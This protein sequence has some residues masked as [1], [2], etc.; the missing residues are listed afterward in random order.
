M[1]VEG[2]DSRQ[3]TEEQL[4][5]LR[6]EENQVLDEILNNNGTIKERVER[7]EQIIK[8]RL[9]LGDPTLDK[10]FTI[11]QISTYITRSLR[12]SNCPTADIVYRY[13][14]DDCKNQSYSKWGKTGKTV[15]MLA[16]GQLPVGYQ[17]EDLSNTEMEVAYEKVLSAKDE[18]D[19][20]ISQLNKQRAQMEFI[21][22]KKHFQLSGNKFRRAIS[23]SDFDE[24]VPKTLEEKVKYNAG[25]I[26]DLGDGLK[27]IAKKYEKSPP[28]VEE[29][30]DEDTLILETVLAV[31]QPLRDFK[32]TGDIIHA[33]ERQYV[34]Q[35]QSKHAAGNSS[36]FPSK[37]CK[38][39]SDIETLRGDPEYELM[40]FDTTSP[41]L[42]RCRK[43]KGTEPR[44]RGM[45]RENVGDRTAVLW[46]A[47]E[48]TV[49]YLPLFGKLMNRLGKRVQ[50]KQ[51]SRK[52]VIAPFFS[53]ASISGATWKVA[54][55]VP[56]D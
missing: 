4:R 17:L 55:E 40:L 39:C 38:N 54:K 45:S 16:E 30:L 12:A 26:N 31:I 20:A 8:R 51:D 6:R 10:S 37:L 52:D 28:M 9:E 14:S 50:M 11:E 2:G 13:V 22:Y 18:F 42:Y 3:Q 25:L 19:R 35:V 23:E 1:L 27:D 21:A 41:S 7:W 49:L 47:A 36:K 33:F 43:C 32:S 24:E 48:N 29:E 44:L 46:N 34:S 15:Q 56:L 53:D 5:E